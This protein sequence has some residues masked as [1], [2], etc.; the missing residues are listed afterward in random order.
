MLR[1]CDGQ[2]PVWYWNIGGQTHTML[3]LSL[4]TF[5]LAEVNGCG[6]DQLL[7]GEEAQRI[8]AWVALYALLSGRRT[9]DVVE[10]ALSHPEAFQ[11]F[12]SHVQD[13]FTGDK[14]EDEPEAEYTHRR[15]KDPRKKITT[16]DGRTMK[17]DDSADGTGTDYRLLFDLS[18]YARISLGD[19]YK[20]TFRGLGELTSYLKD[21]PPVPSSPFGMGDTL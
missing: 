4:S 21:N 11:A 5:A 12:V 18:R 14:T 3:P 20:M 19:I 15:A 7:G 17:P 16:G 8:E 13:S 6:L 9:E 1:L 2:A 10:E